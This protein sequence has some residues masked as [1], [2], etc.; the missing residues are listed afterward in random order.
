MRMKGFTLIELLV[1]ISI[2]GVLTTLVVV[3]YQ[4]ARE[5][6]RDAQRKGDFR[7]LKTA[8]RLYYNDFQGYPAANAGTM[9]ACGADGAN[10]IPCSWGEQWKLEDT[11]YMGRLPVDPLNISD[12]VYSYTQTGSGEDF[13]VTTLLENLSDPAVD[14]SQTNCDYTPAVGKEQTYVVCAN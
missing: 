7:E 10:P 13:E 11:V 5:R 9:I 8:L 4:S 2:I 6:A 14:Q 1:V 12:Y 3:N